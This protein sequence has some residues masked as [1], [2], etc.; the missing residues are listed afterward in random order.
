MEKTEYKE[1]IVTTHGQKR[2]TQ[3]VGGAKHKTHIKANNAL[4]HGITHAEATGLLKQYITD[5]YVS[6]GTANNIRVYNRNVYIFRNEILITVLNLPPNL[7]KIE[8]AIKAK[9]KLAV[10]A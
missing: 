1:S 5:L 6:H 2:I 8:D 9:K 3:R 4:I 10:T 7:H